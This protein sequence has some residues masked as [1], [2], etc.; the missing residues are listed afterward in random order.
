MTVVMILD[1]KNTF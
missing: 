1:N